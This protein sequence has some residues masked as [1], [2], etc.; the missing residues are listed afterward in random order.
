MNTLEFKIKIL[1]AFGNETSKSLK[2]VD[3]WY[4]INDNKPPKINFDF[5]DMNLAIK[6]FCVDKI[7]TPDRYTGYIKTPEGAIL[8][9]ET[10]ETTEFNITFKGIGTL[11]HFITED[12]LM[13]KAK[14]NEW[15]ISRG[16]AFA[17]IFSFGLLVMEIIKFYHSSHPCCSCHH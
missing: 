1:E 13:N 6:K 3:V 2:T 7:L 4:Y 12:T 14:N 9:F 5:N 10:N 17:A 15:L 11:E 8:D 16:A